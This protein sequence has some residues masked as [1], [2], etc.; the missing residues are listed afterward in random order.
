MSLW[1]GPGGRR[2]CVTLTFSLLRG[3]QG[4]L[5]GWQVASGLWQIVSAF[6]TG[7]AKNNDRNQPG[8]ACLPGGRAEREEDVGSEL[9]ITDESGNE[10][11]A[12]WDLDVS[13]EEAATG[14]WELAEGKAKSRALGRLCPLPVPLRRKEKPAYCISQNI[15]VPASGAFL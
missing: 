1:E 11:H 15:T 2:R 7:R 14:R 8:T 9:S 13:P 4:T 5:S 6:D 3:L 12:V 10:I